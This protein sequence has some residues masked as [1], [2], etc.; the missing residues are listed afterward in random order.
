MKTAGLRAVA[1]LLNTS[2]GLFFPC[3]IP[4]HTIPQ[5]ALESLCTYRVQMVKRQAEVGAKPSC[6]YLDMGPG[7]PFYLPHT[8]PLR[9]CVQSPGGSGRPEGSARL[10]CKSGMSS[11][12][13]STKAHTPSPPPVTSINTLLFET[14]GNIV[15]VAAYT[16]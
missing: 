15:V 16:Y 13:Q 14:L 2:M 3:H 10:C 5:R 1:H 6:T 8:G 7:T 4:H 12:N 11:G 9:A